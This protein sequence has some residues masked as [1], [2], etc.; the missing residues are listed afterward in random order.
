L[1]KRVKSIFLL[2]TWLT[3]IPLQATE[4]YFNHSGNQFNYQWQDHNNQPQN[5]SFSVNKKHLHQLFR[6]F[7]TYR[8]ALANHYLYMKLQAELPQ[9]QS[10]YTQIK[11][12]K[13]GEQ[14]QIKIKTRDTTEFHEIHQ[15]ISQL[16]L[17]ILNQYLANHYYTEFTDRFAQAYVKPDHIR[18]AQQAL[19]LFDDIVAQAQDNLRNMSSRDIINYYLSWIQSIPYSTLDNRV[20][21]H[22]AGFSPPNRLLM[23]N[24]GDCDSKSTL[25][26]SLMRALFARLNLVMVY[27]PN[28][29]LV[30][31]QLGH[32]QQDE[33]I[34][35]DGID[36]VLA[37]PTGPGLFKLGEIAEDSKRDIRAGRFSIEELPVNF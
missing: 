36:Y 12:N 4:L 5:L 32:S 33:Y 18:I 29:A 35:L 22:G 20:T 24:Q 30:G 13:L 27:L 19:P 34:S 8:P 37:E 16:R 3:I 31:L 28:H 11:L 6:T 10:R 9:Y 14:V 7:K 25:F 26:I 23:E 1:Q 17:D 2:L 21:S 15:K